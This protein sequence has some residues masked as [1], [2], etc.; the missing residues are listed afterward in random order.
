VLR[1]EL[2]AAA[3]NRSGAY[4]LTQAIL[5]RDCTSSQKIRALLVQAK[6][7]FYLG[8]SSQGHSQLQLA[9]GIAASAGDV[10]LACLVLGTIVDCLFHF[11]SFESGLAHL[12]EFKRAAIR[13]G[14][15]DD[16][17]S[18]R[19]LL[20]EAEL[21]AGRVHRA[22]RELELAAVHSQAAP[23]LAREAQLSFVKGL[24]YISLGQLNSA[25]ADLR[26]AVD[27]AAVAGA[28]TIEEP[29]RNNLA[30]LQVVRGHYA[31]A[32]ELIDQLVNPRP[33]SLDVELLRRATQLQ[34]AAE[35]SAADTADAIQQEFG[36]I[37]ETRDSVHAHWFNLA[38]AAYLLRSADVDKAYTL[39]NSVL[40]RVEGGSDRDL[41]DKTR[42]IV[43]EA[44]ARSSKHGFAMRLLSEV[45]MGPLGRSAE[46]VASAARVA[47]YICSATSDAS[48]HFRRA[49][50]TFGQIG[51]ASGK[52]EA[53]RELESLA[54]AIAEPH[55]QIEPSTAGLTAALSGA[56]ALIDLG[57][58]PVLIG[59]EALALLSTR[60]LALN[61]VL[62]ARRDGRRSPMAWTT[63][64]TFTGSADG[65]HITIPLG[66][67]LG[68]SYELEVEPANDSSA[69]ITLLAI[70]RLVASARALHAAQLAESERSA[71]WPDPLPE[72]Q[73]GFVCASE[74]MLD[75]MRITRRVASSIITVLIT[76]ETGT[77]KELL[78]RAVHQCSPRS[79]ARFLPFNCTAVARDMLD[80]QLFG[81]RRGAFTG[82]Q[83]AFPGVIRGAAGGTLFLD[84]IGEIGLDVQPKLLRFLESSEVHPLG[85]STPVT[86]DVRVVAATNADLDRL[87]AEGKFR[88]DLFY[89]LNVVKL[90]IPPLRERREE[91]PLLLD[92]FLERTMKEAGKTGIRIGESTSEFLLL[93]AWPGNVRELANEVRRVVALAESGSV[94]MPEHLSSKIAA[95]RRTVP[96]A[97]RPLEPTELVVRRDQPLNAAV[98]HVERALI[99]DALRSTANVELAAKRLG[100][101]RKGLYLKRQ[102]LKIDD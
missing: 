102:R 35:T 29:S 3:G 94:V 11:E 24:V 8:R 5:S 73:L 63:S 37:A 39:S 57:A 17:F 22:A 36:P 51:H 43:A 86:V 97:E 95:T 71:I 78:A 53:E 80:S 47:G 23:S 61:A 31:A 30:H 54:S 92:H 75:L 6:V 26:R 18:L 50:R 74:A 91:I 96:V 99:Q 67:E 77:G 42:L 28:T 60:D 64:K 21:K 98:E 65:S 56:A 1:S 68:T 62:S 101:S 59:Q 10:H 48:D 27:V 79:T 19:T 15:P 76:G 16:L 49:A 32:A 46:L 9:R 69:R 20:A 41:I 45:V 33:R 82:A 38:R 70:Q 58:Y 52:R 85:E 12:S 100:L 84:E 88:E 90:T 34:L 55:E 7:D 44:L 14:R 89:R 72:Q 4:D 66:D 13:S 81:Y 25:H 87:M 83:E 40:Q 93:Y 2:E